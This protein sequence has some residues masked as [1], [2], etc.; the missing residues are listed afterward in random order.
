LQANDKVLE[1]GTGSG[2]QAAVLAEIVDEV[3]TIEIISELA[4]TAAERLDRL[5]YGNVH[6]R[7]GDGYF[8]WP[9]EAPFDAVIVTAAP[10]HIPQPL[11]NQLAEGG[12]LV[13][14]VGPP[15]GYQT[16]WQLQKVDGEVQAVNVGGVRFVPLVRGGERSPE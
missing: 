11:I 1:I 3:W 2:Y 16:L 4:E 9:E 13:I 14:P 15:G 8:G 12:Q 10:D 7:Q 5:G 6:V